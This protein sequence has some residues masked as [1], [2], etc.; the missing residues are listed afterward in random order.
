MSVSKPLRMLSTVNSYWYS[1]SSSDLK[2]PIMCD[3]L[4]AVKICKLVRWRH[5]VCKAFKPSWHLRGISEG[6][7]RLRYQRACFS[8]LQN[9]TYTEGCVAYIFE[10]RSQ[11]STLLEIC[12]DTPAQLQSDECVRVVPP[13]RANFLSTAF[14]QW[15][16]SAMPLLR[17]LNKDLVVVLSRLHTNRNKLKGSEDFNWSNI[18]LASLWFVW[19]CRHAW[20]RLMISWRLVIRSC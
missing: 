2:V 11:K 17:C 9:T 12:S 18:G 3:I 7:G 8:E 16:S 20:F 6:V 5:K 4:R 13:F 1:S 15:R 19:F 10:R 14:K